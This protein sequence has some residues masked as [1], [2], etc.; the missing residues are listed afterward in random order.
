MCKADRGAGAD[1]FDHCH[2]R[3]SQSELVEV[4]RPQIV[5]D[6]AYF[7]ERLRNGI[8]E[9]IEPFAALFVSSSHCVE[10]G[11]ILDNQEIL[12]ETVMQ[13]HGDAFALVFL[14]GQQ[15]S[16]EPFS[17]LISLPELCDAVAKCKPRHDDQR[18][19]YHREKP[20]R[21]VKWRQHLKSQ[22][23]TLLIPYAITVSR[24]DSEGVIARWH[25]RKV[26]CPPGPCVYPIVVQSFEFVF[27][28]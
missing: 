13:L 11:A 17:L 1:F 6:R 20:P 2:K 23:L 28:A 18:C 19:R 14:R 10:Q 3:G 24:D 16:S 27:E 4:R 26:S 8:A 7:F 21:L 15:F 5:G 12:T 9:L 22:A 25:M